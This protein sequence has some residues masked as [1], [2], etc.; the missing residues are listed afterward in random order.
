MFA[1]DVVDGMAADGV[2]LVLLELRVDKSFLLFYYASQ[3]PF[4]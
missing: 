1:L 2:Y 4:N 3:L